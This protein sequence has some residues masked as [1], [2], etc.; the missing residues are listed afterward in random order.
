MIRSPYGLLLILC[1]LGRQAQPLRAIARPFPRPARA[2]GAAPTTAGSPHT[3]KPSRPAPRAPHAR[4]PS[5]ARAGSSSRRAGSGAPDPAGLGE[6]DPLLG[7][8]VVAVVIRAVR[9]R[10]RQ[11]VRLEVGADGVIGSGLRR[12]VRGP[13][14]GRR[15]PPATPPPD[16]RG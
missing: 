9:D 7:E 1:V 2:P 13:R 10:H 6:R 15:H 4:A 16:R 14:P 11:P 8:L 12:V 5:R 3:R